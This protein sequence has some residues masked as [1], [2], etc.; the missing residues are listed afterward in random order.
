MRGSPL[1]PAGEAPI[2]RVAPAMAPFQGQQ[3]TQAQPVPAGGGPDEVSSARFS[4]GSL[5]LTQILRRCY[6]V[7]GSLSLEPPG[8]G[9]S[10]P[11]TL[12]GGQNSSHQCSSEQL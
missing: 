11:Q 8:V 1:E 10:G 6:C 3:S 5:C 12:G 4:W 7:G 2:S 9:T